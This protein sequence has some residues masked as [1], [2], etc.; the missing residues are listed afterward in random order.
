MIKKAK[1]KMAVIL[2]LA[3]IILAGTLCLVETMFFYTHVGDGFSRI[4]FPESSYFLYD[5]SVAD[6]NNDGFLDIF[7]SNH[8]ALQ[9]VMFGDGAGRFSDSLASLHLHQDAIFPGIENMGSAILPSKEGVYIYWH[10]NTLNIRNYNASNE[11][12]IEGQL[13][14]YAD[15]K[16]IRSNDRDVKAKYLDVQ[17]EKTLLGATKTTIKFRLGNGESLELEPELIAIPITVSIEKGYKL[18]RLFLGPDH[19]TPKNHGFTIFLRDRHGMAWADFTGDGLLDLFI[20]RGGLKG[21]MLQQPLQSDFV[22]ELLVSVGDHFKNITFNSGLI[23]KGCSGHQAAWVDFNNDGMLDLYVTC[24]RAGQPNQLYKQTSNYTFEDVAKQDNLDLQGKW[25]GPFLWLDFDNDQDQDLI[26]EMNKKFFLYVNDQGVF[27]RQFIT[28]NKGGISKLTVSDYDSDG[29]QDIYAASSVESVLLINSGDSFIKGN[30]SDLG[31]PL[32]AET[33]NWLDYDNDGLVDLHVV[34]GGL[35]MQHSNNKF[36]RT[37]LL[38]HI[39]HIS[40]EDAR[41]TWFDMDNDGDRDLVVAIKYKPSFIESLINRLTGNK[42]YKRDWNIYLYKNDNEGN[43]WLEIQLVGLKNNRQAIGA[44]VVLVGEDGAVTQQ[45]VGHAE[46][47]H[48]SQG[49]YRLY[50]GLGKHGKPKSLH[51]VWPDGKL[52]SIKPVLDKVIIVEYEQ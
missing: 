29:D 3:L 13:L 31:L 41:S 42:V 40:V 5:I 47:A 34:P 43:H 50:F 45:V 1:K 25:L 26:L 32:R 46:G 48:S 51:V 8:F 4:K 16:V 2:A 36:T 38:E 17:S 12:D 49:H 18:S 24:R 6:V 19:V 20:A 21:R 23:K 10:K 52:Q 9:R 37:G 30:I 14:F 11:N 27:K 22:D 7:T 35:F 44:R 39:F 15:V 28:S 33:A